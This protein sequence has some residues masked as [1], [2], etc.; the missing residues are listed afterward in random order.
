MDASSLL[1]ILN[2]YKWTFL[3]YAAVIFLIYLN[4]R[5]LDWP[6]K[7]LG[8]YRTKAGLKLMDRMGKHERLFRTLGTIGIYV[9]F[10]GMALIVALLFKGLYDLVF[11]PSAPPV[12]SPVIPG[13]MIPGVGIK[14]PLIIGWIALFVVI[15]IHE[16]SHGVVAR[17]HRIKVQSSGL[18]FLGPLGGAFVEPDEKALVKA[19]KKAQL[20]IFAAGPFSNLLSSLALYLVI[21]FV[22]VPLLVYFVAANGV[23]F[24]SV[25]PGYPAA[26]AGVRTGV[27]YDYV[28]NRSVHDSTEFTD[29]LAG[30][31]P[32]DQV[33]LASS[34][35]KESMVF[36]A[37]ASPTNASR[38]YLGVVLGTNLRWPGLSW[39]FAAYGWLV[40]IAM[41]TFILGLGI[42]LANLLPLGPVDGGRMLQVA[43]EHL[44]GKQ[45]GHDVWA[46]ISICM[47]AVIAILLLVPLVK[48]MF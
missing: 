18:M 37:A 19:P 44:F 47:I 26:A 43:A 45:R 29:A 23:V 6:A 35:A 24:S 5:K 38:G 2:D 30:V 14:V 11:V 32:G 16:F 10:A 41:W 46:K 1:V 40:E 8:L 20:G 13:A 25:Q 4:R 12:I 28:N 48:W 27:V 39:L 34:Q 33:I 31:K 22:L 7:F 42:G 17:A 21:G 15:V 9:G 36:T 3:F